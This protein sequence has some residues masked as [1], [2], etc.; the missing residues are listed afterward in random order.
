MSSSHH[1]EHYRKQV[2]YLSRTQ[3]RSSGKLIYNWNLTA[4]GTKQ[5][6]AA[7]PLRI[8]PPRSTANSVV[9]IYTT[10]SIKSKISNRQY[11]SLFYTI[12]FFI[13]KNLLLHPNLHA[14]CDCQISKHFSMFTL[15]ATKNLLQL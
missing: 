10:R 12:T 9:S 7:I 14:I 3:E 8:P 13:L 4:N 1:T 6:T 5:E 15:A 2:C 11:R